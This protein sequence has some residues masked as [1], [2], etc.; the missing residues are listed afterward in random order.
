MSKHF[1]FPVIISCTGLIVSVIVLFFGNNIQQ[2]FQGAELIFTSHH[3]EIKQPKKKLTA[4]PD[5]LDSI[6]NFYREVRIKNIGG[7]PS[8]ML[9]LSMELDGEIIESEISCIESIS[10]IKKDGVKIEIRMDRLV[11]N[12]EVVC[13]FWLVQKPGSLSITS[14]D[15]NGI[16]VV[17]SSESK[18]EVSYLQTGSILVIVLITFFLFYLF[19]LKPLISHN[20][21][22][23]RQS[24]ELQEQNDYLSTELNELK[25]RFEENETPM[26]IIGQLESL[27][28]KHQN[29]A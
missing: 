25:S 18:A 5:V 23:I 11:K 21:E 19:Y 15:N 3:M 27:I 7:N 14:I 28:R 9:K 13:K 24:I 20:S 10:D 4:V 1:T 2:R 22:L 26:N 16:N 6:P 12:A 8:T 29:E 17:E